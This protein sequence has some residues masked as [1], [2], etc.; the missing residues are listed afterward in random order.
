MRSIIIQDDVKL[1][2][3]RLKQFEDRT[4]CE[5]LLVVANS[6]D[7]YPGATF[8]FGIISTFIIALV[9]TYYLEFHHA[10]LYPLSFFA[11]TLLMSYVGHFPWAKR[12]ALSEWEVE[13]E[14]AEKA[15]EYFHTLGT[16]KVSHKVT[17]MIMVSV[18]EKKIH[19]LVD[20]KL[21]EQLDQSE[22]QELVAIMQ[23][24][25]KAGNMG[26]GFIQSI[27]SLEEKILLD[28]G[29]KINNLGSSELKD[30]IHFT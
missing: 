4:G 1:V 5:L 28:F 12:L 13:R 8:R 18:L 10:Y 25:F 21:K 27:D 3:A 23:K 15:L 6:S 22:L 26:L 14:T 30:I 24:H 17:A 11:L 19:I 7:P 2:E 20:E 9:F 16:T 29:G